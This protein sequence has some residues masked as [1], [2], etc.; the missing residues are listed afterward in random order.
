M[1]FQSHV[2]HGLIPRPLLNPVIVLYFGL[3]TFPAKT[4]LVEILS[5]DRETNSKNSE[6]CA[7][8]GNQD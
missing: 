4:P 6:L 8:Y 1:V 2:G 3:A 7:L 5:F